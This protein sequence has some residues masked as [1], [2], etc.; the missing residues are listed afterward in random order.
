[1]G[2]G[3]GEVSTEVMTALELLKNLTAEKS[4][5]GLW[6]TAIAFRSR[7][8]AWYRA[9]AVA[10]FA[11]VAAAAFYSRL[12]VSEL[13]ALTRKLC[14]VGF[15]FAGTAFGILLAGF[16]IFATIG[17]SELAQR[18]AVL[19]RGGEMSEVKKMALHFTRAFVPLLLLCIVTFAVMA[20][21]FY[22]GPA[23]QLTSS[24]EPQAAR[25]LTSA[26]CAAVA[27]LHVHV[28]TVLASFVFNV[29]ISLMTMVK[30]KVYPG[31]AELEAEAI[32][33]LKGETTPPS[34]ATPLPSSAPRPDSSAL[35]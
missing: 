3:H 34:E 30:A 20:L 22:G 17:T 10:T 6:W 2:G 12:T 25:W 28:F 5:A 14:E 31:M 1:M 24:L 35:S 16:A 8:T 7:L 9:S 15:G 29:H 23:T 33:E 11:G 19:P 27:A 13:G 32:A 18:L 21:G 4:L 26:C